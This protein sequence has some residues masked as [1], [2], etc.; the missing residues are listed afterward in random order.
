MVQPIEDPV[1]RAFSDLPGRCHLPLGERAAHVGVD[2][3][4]VDA[5][6][7]GA[8]ALEL[9]AKTVSHGEGRMLCSAVG[10]IERVYVPGDHGEHVD[11]HATA[12]ALQYGHEGVGHIHYAKDVYYH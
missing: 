3:A 6:D 9:V 4:G 11:H 5:Y 12:I 8:L 1:H 2:E 7:L 10:R